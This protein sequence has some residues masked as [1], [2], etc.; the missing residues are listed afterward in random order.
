ME[1]TILEVVTREN[2][3]FNSFDL[4]E[5]TYIYELFKA[6]FSRSE[7]VSI[8]GEQ[9]YEPLPYSYMQVKQLSAIFNEN[10]MYFDYNLSKSAAASIQFKP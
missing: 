9:K 5:N 6:I 10:I 4:P 1:Q 3:A 2:F 7:E 8:F